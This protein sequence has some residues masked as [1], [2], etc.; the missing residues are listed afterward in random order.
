MPPEYFKKILLV[1]NDNNSLAV[2]Y[3]VKYVLT[4]L[5]CSWTHKYLTKRNENRFTHKKTCA[6][7][8]V[9]ALFM[10]TKN[11]KKNPNVHQEVCG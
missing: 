8:F 5:S 2:Y 11:G 3:K 4:I 7:V 1:N 6:Q 9:D 10:I